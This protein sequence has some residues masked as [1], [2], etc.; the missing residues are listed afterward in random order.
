AFGVE[1]LHDLGVFAFPFTHLPFPFGG[2][3]TALV[4]EDRVGVEVPQ[5]GAG[6]LNEEGV[7]AFPGA[8]GTGRNGVESF[9]GLVH[10]AVHDREQ[11]VFFAFEV[12]VDGRFGESDAVRNVVQGRGVVAL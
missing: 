11:H 2:E 12:V 6:V 8:A 3:E 5:D 7:D 1:A 4:V 10:D 9:Q